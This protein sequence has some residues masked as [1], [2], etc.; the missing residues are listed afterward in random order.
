MYKTKQK[1]D[2]LTLKSFSIIFVTILIAL[3]I[4]LCTTACTQTN[5]IIPNEF[6]NKTAENAKIDSKYNDLAQ[7]LT[8]EGI[9]EFINN[10]SKIPHQSGHVEQ[11]REYLY[12]WGKSNNLETNIDVSGCVYMD[13]PASQGFENYP[14][15]IL[16]SHMDMVAI[17]VDKSVDMATTPL[18]LVYD[19][20][21]G[22][23]Y[24]RDNKTSIGADDGEGIITML[25]IAKS[26][27]VK[28]GPLR[29]I[30]TYD[31]ETTM[32][33]AKNISDDVLNSDYIINIDNSYTGSVIY[34]S[35]GSIKSS[36]SKSYSLSPVNNKCLV[37]LNIENLKGG[38]SGDDITKP[39]V[40]AICYE[41]DI[42][43]KLKEIN[44]KYNIVNF[45]GGTVA[46]SIPDHCKLEILVDDNDVEKVESAANE[47]KEQLK[48]A[49]TDENDFDVKIEKNEKTSTD[50][51]DEA[52]TNE[53][54]DVINIYPEGVIKENPDNKDVPI[55]SNNIGVIKCKDG[56]VEIA[57][58]CRSSEEEYLD[59]IN[60]DLTKIQ[61]EKHYTYTINNKY[62]SWP[63]NKDSKLIQLAKDSYKNT[64]NI[65]A[66]VA[67]IHAGLECSFFHIKKPSAQIVSIGGDVQHEHAVTETFYTKSFPAHM[68]SVLY[69]LENINS[70]Q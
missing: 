24:S 31:E 2:K 69:L 18:D 6:P 49:K 40:N 29:L 22:K 32:Q 1:K 8:E 53:I 45:S 33:G 48:K 37:S 39:R 26:N 36:I 23:I 5:K 42:L 43:N 9:N 21:S 47:Q 11:I 58:Q 60:D 61:N 62:P 16:Q 38:H 13:V 3:S 59:K 44:V 68:A 17:N 51:F 27:K 64:A 28:H 34:S 35:A 4:E 52:S 7:D 66:D 25:S 20:D 70:A 15:V 65:E 55:A 10:I 30:F 50:A 14:N 63:G 56:N 54:V 57:D 67:A 19:K 46:N 41:R 12:N